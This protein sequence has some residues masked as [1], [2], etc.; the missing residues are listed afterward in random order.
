V[1]FKTRAEYLAMGL[2]IILRA[3]RALQ[4]EPRYRFTLDPPCY[5]EPFPARYPE[6]EALFCKLVAE[7]RLQ[8]V[9]G[10]DSMADVNIPS[11]ESFVCQVLECKG[12]YRFRLGAEVTAG[13]ALDT[14][15][16]HP[17]MP[18]LLRQ[19]GFDSLFMARGV[20]ATQAK[21]EFMWQ[22]IEGSQV[23]FLWLPY[24]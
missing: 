13:W 7:G 16:M 11:G 24:S 9:C 20:P 2:P 5:V 6:Q 10:M 8:L 12:F 21:S 22:R 19:S 18:Q 15:G 1:V 23:L 14:F 3:N 4:D 17:Q